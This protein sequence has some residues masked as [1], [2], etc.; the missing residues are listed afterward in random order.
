[1]KII[2]RRI[3]DVPIAIPEH[4][5]HR[6]ESVQDMLDLMADIHYRGARKLMIHRD[7]LHPDFFDLSSGLAGEILQKFSNYYMQLA[8]VGKNSMG[9]SKSFNDFVRECNAGQQVFF[10]ENTDEAIKYLTR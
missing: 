1:V 7:Q 5:D 9:K 8:I 10:A 2:I 3:H 4:I 6:I